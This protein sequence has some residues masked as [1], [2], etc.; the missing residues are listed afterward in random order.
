[1]YIYDEN[2]DAISVKSNNRLVK[3]IKGGF[4]IRWSLSYNTNIC[5]ICYSSII[6][7]ERRYRMFALYYSNF[8]YKT[9]EAL[10]TSQV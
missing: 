9:D 3:P 5:P 8:F 7:K 4:F 2:D 10:P 1:M 6:P